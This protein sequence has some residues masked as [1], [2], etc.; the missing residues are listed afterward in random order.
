VQLDLC[1]LLGWHGAT[2]VANGYW[3]YGPSLTNRYVHDFNV[4]SGIDAYDTVRLNELWLQQKLFD[5]R[6]SLK[7]GLLVV[8]DDFSLLPSAAFFLNSVFSNTSLFTVNSGGATFPLAA[9]GIRAEYKATPDWIVRAG[10]YSGDVGTENGNNTRGGRFAFSSAGG[11]L[12]M[13]EIEHHVKLTSAQLPG[14]L[15]LGGF[16]D[17]GLYEDFS[18]SSGDLDRGLGAVYASW[19]QAIYRAPEKSDDKSKDAPGESCPKDDD[20]PDYRGVNFFLR[21]GLSLPSQVAIIGRDVEIGLSARGML[22]GREKDV[23]GIAYGYTHLGDSVHVLEGQTDQDVSR[24]HEAILE[25]SYQYYVCKAFNLQPDVQ[26][27]FNPG[28]AVR[29]TT[30]VV[31]GLR[32]NLSF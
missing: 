15:L 20:P 10:V 27:I 31:V 32:A 24:H 23:C 22:F 16:Y 14:V 17:T 12:Y 21:A 9:P 11:G 4:L 1:K 19:D 30:A 8:D 28:A 13:L 6:L 26:V 29:A 5:D 25:A 2:F 3:S 7:A 18:N